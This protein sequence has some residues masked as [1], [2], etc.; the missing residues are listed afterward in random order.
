MLNSIDKESCVTNGFIS[1]ITFSQ[2]L[3]HSGLA[4]ILLLS[5]RFPT[6]GNDNHETSLI[7]VFIIE[8]TLN[9]KS[10]LAPLF[11]RGVIPP[12]GKGRLGGI[13]Q[14]LYVLL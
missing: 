2:P 4:R 5:E 3:C 8:Q 7:K 1:K 13:F 14:S 11:Q 12:F 6:S 9:K 10:P